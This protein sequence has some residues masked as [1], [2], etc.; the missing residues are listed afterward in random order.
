MMAIMP[1]PQEF[2]VKDDNMDKID[3][4]TEVCAVIGLAI[5]AVVMGSI[6]W[7]LLQV[8]WEFLIG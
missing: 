4:V 5:F 3:F 7:M 6:V 8:I 2:F 1:C